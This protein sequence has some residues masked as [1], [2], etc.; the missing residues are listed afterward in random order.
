MLFHINLFQHNQQYRGL[1]CTSR[2]NNNNKLIIKGSKTKP[3]INTEFILS[4]HVYKS[5]H[6]RYD[7]WKT[8]TTL[9]NKEDII[10]MIIAPYIG[11]Q[12]HHHIII[13]RKRKD[14]KHLNVYYVYTL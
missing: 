7:V 2:T 3:V 1:I 13:D 10:E 5:K 6:G 12:I 14:I 11:D 4:V 8:P 9:N